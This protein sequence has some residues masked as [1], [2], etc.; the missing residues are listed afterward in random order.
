MP[1]ARGFTGQYADA[2]TGLD[3]YGARYYDP[4]VGQFA[5]ADTDAKGGLNRY[6][7]V[8]G[9]PETKTD[10]SGHRVCDDC[11]SNTGGGWPFW[12]NWRKPNP[13]SYTVGWGLTEEDDNCYPKGCFTD[14]KYWRTDPE[15]SEDGSVLASYFGIHVTRLKDTLAVNGQLVNCYPAGKCPDYDV[16]IQ[17]SYAAGLYPFRLESG[18][19]AVDLYTP[20][21]GTKWDNTEGNYPGGIVNTIIQKGAEQASIVVVDLRKVDGAATLSQAQLN[22]YAARAVFSPYPG[23]K[24]PSRV[25]RVLFIYDGK[26]VDDYNPLNYGPVKADPNYVQPVMD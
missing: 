6:A 5:Q 9:N 4:A 23:L 14:Q 24:D 19:V 7:Y 15:E 11:D 10:P 12:S 13:R 3:Y 17:Q 21:Q 26:V 18:H 22:E 16:Y 25:A 8:G 1:T 2:S 20:D